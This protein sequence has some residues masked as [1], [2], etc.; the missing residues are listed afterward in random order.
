MYYYKHFSFSVDDRGEVI[1]MYNRMFSHHGGG[2]C[3]LLG[4]LK[5]CLFT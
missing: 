5:M 1:K 3:K 2:Q 4:F